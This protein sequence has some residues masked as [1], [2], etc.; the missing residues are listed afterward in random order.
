LI[1]NERQRG[2]L[3]PLAAEGKATQLLDEELASAQALEAEGLLFLVGITAVVTPKGRRRLADL[4]RKPK[5]SK[6]PLGFLD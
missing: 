6:T 4:E 2:L 5:P 3:E 1:K